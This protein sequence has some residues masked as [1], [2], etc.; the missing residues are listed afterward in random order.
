MKNFSTFPDDTLIKEANLLLHQGEF[1]KSL[2]MLLPYKNYKLNQ[3]IMTLIGIAYAGCNYP[4]EAAYHLCIAQQLKDNPQRHIC[5]ELEA[6]L[7]SYNLYSF[8]FRVFEKAFLHQPKNELLH[9]AYADVLQHTKHP[10]K[11]ILYIKK[12]LEFSKNKDRLLNILATIFFEAGKYSSAIKLYQELEKRNEN[13][14]TVLANLSCYYNAINDTNQALMYSRKAIMLQPSWAALRVNYSICLLKAECYHQGWIEHDW[15]LAT[16]NHSTLPKDKLIPTLTD[17]MDI[18]GKR[19]LLTQEEG[20]GDTL[21]YIRFVPELIRRGAIVELWIAETMKGLCERIKGKPKVKVGGED[22]P[23]FDWHC[24]FI[25]LPR[26]L[27][28]DPNQEKF[29]S[30]LSAD[31]KKVAYWKEILPQTK[32]FKVGLVWGGSPHPGDVNAM[33]TDNKRSIPLQ[34]LIP[35]L[36]SVK[37]ATFISLQMGDH[38]DEIHDLP[39]DVS[40]FNPMT[41]VKDMDDTAGIIKNLDLVISVDTSVIHLAGGLG[42]KAILLDRYDNCWRWISNKKYSPWYPKVRIVRQTHPRIWSDV[43]KETTSLLQKMANKHEECKS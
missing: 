7:G 36:R 11:A 23:P 19:I 5:S 4:K 12:C 40:I 38:T 29:T 33:M 18:T 28:I 37:N 2:N 14:I 30:Y 20:L 10:A 8:I 26:A 31:R 32:K 3:S 6:Y 25:S 34:K 17:T 35:L 15:R 27:S 24:P 16:P 9:I 43:V 22:P 1:E 21:M 41:D 39:E 13:N 42:A